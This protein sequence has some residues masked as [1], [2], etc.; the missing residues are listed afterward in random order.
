MKDAIFEIVTTVGIVVATGFLICVCVWA[1]FSLYKHA[2]NKDP[3]S[4]YRALCIKNEGKP[5]FNGK[6][7]E[8]MK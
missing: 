1:V 2:I 4:E 3:V 7:W 5:V 6:Y 8:C